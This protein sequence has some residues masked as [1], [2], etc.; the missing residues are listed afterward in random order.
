M[1]HPPPNPLPQKPPLG[2]YGGSILFAAPRRWDEACFSVPALRAIRA[3][4]P[5]CTLGVLC[6]EEQSSLWQSVPGLNAIIA[7]NDKSN[8][9][10]MLK[11]EEQSR[12]DWDCA[13]LWENDI[14]AQFCHARKI[15]Q[16]LAYSN[17]KMQKWITDAVPLSDEPGPVE[18]RVQ[19][20][21][22]FM[23]RLHVNT[24]MPQLFTPCPMDIARSPKHVIV[25][26]SSDYGPSYE[27]TLDHW[28]ETMHLLLKRMGASVTIVNLPVPKSFIAR[29]LADQFPE[30]NL[31]FLPSFDDAFP[32]LAVASLTI[33]ADSSLC[34]L[35]A[36]LGTPT[37][38][39]FGPNDPTWRR[40][41]G[42]R[43]AFVRRK[44]ECSPCLLP[45]CPL[46]RRCQNEL[47]FEEVARVIR[48][49]WDA[50]A[51]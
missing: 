50:L 2:L 17:K 25:S 47:T 51:T 35:S 14:A 9:R 40:P 8:V 30:C 39:L 33:A 45:K 37:I 7:Y 24:Q 20:Y 46:D 23:Q 29:E 31:E 43:N 10:Q 42:R 4:R 6:H 15:K 28:K 49:K 5:N 16:R 32:H 3:A 18:H 19:Y 44:V 27:W 48:E 22:R 12:Y 26:P 38:A 34:H 21:L 11:Q 13:I 41:L 36:H 1:S